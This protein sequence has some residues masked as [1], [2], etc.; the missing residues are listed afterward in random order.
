MAQPP[1]SVRQSLRGLRHVDS[2]GLLRCPARPC[3]PLSVLV[4]L[5]QARCA[6]HN[7]LRMHEGR[8]MPALRR[9][10]VLSLRL[11]LSIPW[12]CGDWLEST[13]M[14]VGIGRLKSTS[15]GS[16]G[17]ARQM[18]TAAT[19]VA[20]PAES[21][22]LTE[23]RSPRSQGSRRRTNPRRGRPVDSALRRRPPWTGHGRCRAERRAA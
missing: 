22:S 2:R 17:R 23:T 18:R 14:P 20:G 7:S 12:R 16:R 21:A 10:V 8:E 3:R 6:V 9:R 11:R 19:R 5:T 4:M 1:L 15:Q 13:R